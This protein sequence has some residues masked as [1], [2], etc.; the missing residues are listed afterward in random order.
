MS[1]KI[2][3]ETIPHS[4]Q[5][6]DTVGDWFFKPDATWK[7]NVSDLADWRYE[8]LVAVHELVEMGLC[9]DRG[10]TAQRIDRFDIAY[11]NNRLPGDTTE[12]GDA[13]DA[14]YRNEHCAATGIERIL[15]AHLGID[16]SD[17]EKTINEL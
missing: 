15:A 4:R 8:L 12:P 14:P 3:I 13:T 16:W 1:L 5:R 17:Y 7:I 6:Y 9:N 10:I 11:E 2:E